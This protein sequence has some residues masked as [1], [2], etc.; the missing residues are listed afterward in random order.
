MKVIRFILIIL[1][2]TLI[3]LRGA[4]YKLL[5]EVLIR[6][7]KLELYISLIEVKVKERP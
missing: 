4:Q 7:T 3:T 5:K 2:T 6:E 1:L